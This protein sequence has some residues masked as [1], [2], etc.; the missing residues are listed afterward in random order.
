MGLKRLAEEGAALDFLTAQDLQAVNAI[1]GRRYYG[2][3]T[4]RFEFE[5]DKALASLVGHPLLFWMDSPGTRVELLPGEPELLVKAKGG[6]VRIALQPPL[7]DQDGDVIVTRETPTRLR[8][9]Q[10]KDEHR[11]IGAILGEGL[12]V[13]REDHVGGGGRVGE[14]RGSCLHGGTLT[15]I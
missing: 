8:L 10:V 7:H 12:E 2:S 9:V 5:R 13:P 11:R 4:V 1:A 14:D 15:M 3:S 6:T